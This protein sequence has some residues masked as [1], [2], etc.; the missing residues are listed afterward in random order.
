MIYSG[1]SFG[2]GDSRILQ[3]C[4]IILLN[5]AC[6]LSFALSWQSFDN[7]SPV[8]IHYS[9]VTTILNENPVIC[10]FTSTS[11]KGL[12]YDMLGYAN[13]H[14]KWTFSKRRYKY[15]FLFLSQCFNP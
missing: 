8:T 7:N 6:F 13:L 9:P 10:F 3:L 11:I 5:F 1:C 2:K 14:A 4:R 15:F 12:M